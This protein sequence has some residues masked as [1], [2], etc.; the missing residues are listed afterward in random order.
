MI[1]KIKTMFG[2][3]KRRRHYSNNGFNAVKSNNNN[4]SGIAN[5]LHDIKSVFGSNNNHKRDLNLPK[6]EYSFGFD[7]VKKRIQAEIKLLRK[8]YQIEFAENNQGYLAVI[9]FPFGKEWSENKAELLIRIPEN[10]P[11]CQ[12]SVYY[13][14]K[15]MLLKNKILSHYLDPLPYNELLSFNWMKFRIERD[16]KPWMP[17]FYILEGDSLLTT[18][19]LIKSNLDK[20]ADEAYRESC[21]RLSKIA[22]LN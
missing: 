9:D 5:T 12:P 21:I 17:S 20:I 4:G 15:T 2:L 14:K 6:S 1:T 10:Y 22:I 13:V 19:E 11:F 16:G 8:K 18:I 7:S 3:K